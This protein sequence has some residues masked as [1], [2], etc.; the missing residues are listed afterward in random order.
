MPVMPD[1]RSAAKTSR[2]LVFA[3]VAEADGNRTR[4]RYSAA[5]TSFEDWG[6]H[7]A[8]RRLRDDSTGHFGR[9]RV[10][11]AD[12]RV[13][14]GAY[15]PGRTHKMRGGRRERGRRVSENGPAWWEEAV[16]YEVY[17]RSFV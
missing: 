5:L 15:F 10:V 3:Q 9:P 14:R 1:A 12:M 7:Q 6:D 2:H 13:A 4:Q 8:P 11:L 17:P 16:V